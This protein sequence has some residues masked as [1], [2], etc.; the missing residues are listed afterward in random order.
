MFSSVFASWPSNFTVFRVF[1]RKSCRP[2]TIADFSFC[3]WESFM[4]SFYDM[5][6]KFF[7]QYYEKKYRN[8]GNFQYHFLIKNFLSHVISP[9]AMILGEKKYSHNDNFSDNKNRGAFFFFFKSCTIE[10]EEVKDLRTAA[11]GS[12]TCSF[13]FPQHQNGNI[14]SHYH[15]GS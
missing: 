15:G 2:G 10:P 12:P 6:D 3:K 11:W 13:T 14:Y 7:L 5:S 9:Y 1:D 8:F 4:A